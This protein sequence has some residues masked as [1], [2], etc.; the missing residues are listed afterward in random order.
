MSEV[1][2]DRVVLITGGSK[3]IGRE[4]GRLFLDAGFRLVITGRDAA[5]LDRAADDLG[6]DRR[7][8]I[9]MLPGDVSVEADCRRWIEQTVSHF[10]RLDILINNA[11]MSARGVFAETDLGVYRRLTGI[12]FLGPVMMSRLALDQIRKNRGSILFV[13]TL[14]ALKGLRVSRTTEQA[15][16]L[17]PPSVRLSGENSGL[18]VCISVWCMSVLPRT[19]MGKP[20]TT[21]RDGGLF[22]KNEKTV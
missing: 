5:A 14:A 8:R 15:N 18:R 9:L 12:N 3:G 7:D 6:K 4:T 1:F 13:S 17:S 19:T 22:W 2:Q 16:F 20:S 10:G 21:H 11:G